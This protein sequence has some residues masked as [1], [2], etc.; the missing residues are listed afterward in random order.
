M[1]QNDNQGEWA[2][3]P[4]DLSWIRACQGIRNTHDM[5]MSLLMLS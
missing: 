1:Y 2:A 5:G 3:A 4:R